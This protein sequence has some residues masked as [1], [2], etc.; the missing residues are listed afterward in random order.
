MKQQRNIER[1]RSDS[2]TGNMEHGV[3]KDRSKKCITKWNMWQEITDGMAN[4]V[5]CV[6]TAGAGLLG[7]LAVCRNAGAPESATTDLEE[8]LT[9]DPDLL[10]RLRPYPQES[11]EHFGARRWETCFYMKNFMYR[12]SLE[13]ML[14]K[15][16][17]MMGQ[18]RPLTERTRP[19][20]IRSQHA[21][22][23]QHGTLDVIR[24][25]EHDRRMAM[26]ICTFSL[27]LNQVMLTARNAGALHAYSR[28]A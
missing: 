20:S 17:P 12:N 27:G 6:V 11:E 26:A 21:V 2:F 13:A 24:G 14:R 10:T 25:P 19:S 18:Y 9:N 16:R 5:L 23:L 7:F 22:L 28:A 4:G 8:C 1:T 15:L 3:S